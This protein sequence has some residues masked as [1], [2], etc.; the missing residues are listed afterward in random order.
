[1][2]VPLTTR[3]SAGRNWANWKLSLDGL[4]EAGAEN[5]RTVPM[6]EAA[7]TAAAISL[8]EVDKGAR[9]RCGPHGW[10]PVEG[11]DGRARDGVPE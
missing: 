3:L 11:N 5:A 8:R 2:F 7:R 4:A 1:M 10:R 6:A 9:F